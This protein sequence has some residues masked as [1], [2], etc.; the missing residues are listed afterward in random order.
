MRGGETKFGEHDKQAVFVGSKESVQ[1]RRTWPLDYFKN[2]CVRI[3]QVMTD[4]D[5]AYKS[6]RFAKLLRRLGIKRIRTRP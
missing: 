2:L 1:R 4:D 5:S 6:R 3:G